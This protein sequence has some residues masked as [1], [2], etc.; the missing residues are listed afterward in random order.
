MKIYQT[1]DIDLALIGKL[2]DNNYTRRIKSHFLA[3]GTQYDFLRFFVMEHKGE[4]LGM[5]SEFNSA[6]MISTFEGKELTEEMI[7]D[8]AGFVRMLKPFSV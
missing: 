2:K 6:L 3:Y 8:L 4:R 7:E 1:K 5:F